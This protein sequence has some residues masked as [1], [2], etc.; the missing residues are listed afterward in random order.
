MKSAEASKWKQAAEEEY[1]SLLENKTWSLEDLPPGRIPIEGKW[2]F[3]RKL[4]SD[5]NVERY[6]ARLVVRG[7][8]QVSGVDYVE[9]ELYSPVVQNQ[10]I[11]FMVALSAELD[12]LLE[13]MDVVTAFLNGDLKETVYI[14]QP[15]GFEN[16]DFPDKFCRL[17]KALY[18]LKQSPKA[19]FEKI[20]EFLISIGFKHS[21]SDPNL[22]IMNEKEGFA[23]LALYVDDLVVAATLQKLMDKIKGALTERFKMKELGDLSYCLGV[24]VVRNRSAGTIMLHQSKY[25]SEILQRFNLTAATLSTPMTTD[26]KLSK[27][28]Q[29]QGQAEID[30]MKDV[31]YKQS[32][33]CLIYL[34]VWTRPDISKATQEVAKY[35][36]NPGRAHWNAVKR[37]YQYLLSTRDYGLVYHGSGTGKLSVV[38]WSDADWASDP[39]ERR[40]I[41]AFVFTINGTA[42]TWNC[43]LLPTICLSSAESEYGAL[44][45]AGKE[46]VSIRI[47]LSD[48]GQSMDEP[49]LINS[50]SQ[51]VIALASSSR[52]HSRT[53]HIGVAQHFIR[54][55]IQDNQAVLRYVSTEDNVADLLTKAL[56]RDKHFMLMTRIRLQSLTERV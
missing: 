19:W 9:T 26:V 6:K 22:Y 54:Q 3:R 23:T 43:K 31:P 28:Q 13:H 45:R 24:H 53:R 52:F 36:R 2:I 55:L 32:V 25:V 40:S 18:G 5:G 39:D 4:G 27:D 1:N 42:I 38:G 51:S 17:L 37:I 44:S 33:G 35:S 47:T 29:P 15:Q 34:N 16:S 50:D 14:R 49:M 11:R 10:S 30:E 48:V 21:Q 56:S 46:L 41:A 8:K 20:D 12:M 7:F